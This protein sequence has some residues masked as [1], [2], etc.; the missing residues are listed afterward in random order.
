[1]IYSL[2]RLSS[3]C[4]YSYNHNQDLQNNRVYPSIKQSIYPYK[5]QSIS[6]S[7]NLPLDTTITITITKQTSPPPF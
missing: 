7:H 2:V 3:S 5:D 6:Q 1:M 4:R